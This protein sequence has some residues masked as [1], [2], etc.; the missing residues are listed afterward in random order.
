MN[1]GRLPEFCALLRRYCAVACLLPKNDM[2]VQDA[3]V[4]AT[5][6]VVLQE[7]D[8]IQKEIDS[9][10]AGAVRTRLRDSDANTASH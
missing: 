7:L 10:L 4:R 6:V 2:D 3:N 9:F 5:A 1:P 8:V